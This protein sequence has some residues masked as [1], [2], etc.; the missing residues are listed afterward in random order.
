VYDQQWSTTETGSTLVSEKVV[1]DCRDL[2]VDQMYA[3][4]Y[5]AISRLIEEKEVL[6]GEV[7]ALTAQQASLL[8]WAQSQG[9]TG[10]Q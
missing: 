4:M 10:A 7:T 9:F 6:Q 5:G 3:V 8:A 1:E 2:N